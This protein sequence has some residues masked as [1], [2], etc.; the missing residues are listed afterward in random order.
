MSF[1]VRFNIRFHI[2]G[3]TYKLDPYFKIHYKKLRTHLNPCN[4]I[5]KDTKMGILNLKSMYNIVLEKGLWVKWVGRF[6]CN[7]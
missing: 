7:V 6:S 1:E 4:G 3:L 5:Q 2:L